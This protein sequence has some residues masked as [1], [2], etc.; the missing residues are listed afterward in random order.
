MAFSS[1]IRIENDSLSRIEMPQNRYYRAETPLSNKHFNI[2][3][4]TGIK[5]FFN[6][7]SQKNSI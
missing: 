5:N 1:K 4:P 3:L 2:G 6:L 7:S